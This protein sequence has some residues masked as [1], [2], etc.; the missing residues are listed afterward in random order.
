MEYSNMILDN[1]LSLKFRAVYN[2]AVWNQ[3]C[4]SRGGIS[5]AEHNRVV[6]KRAVLNSVISPTR[7]YAQLFLLNIHCRRQRVR[8]ALARDI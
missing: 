5:R 8:V 2:M 4:L 7:W 3:D 1:E 6:F